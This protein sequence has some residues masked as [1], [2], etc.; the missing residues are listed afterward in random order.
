MTWRGVVGLY[1]A[2]WY[3]RSDT[4]AVPADFKKTRV[5]LI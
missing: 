1:I 5:Y 4:C 3:R 2:Q